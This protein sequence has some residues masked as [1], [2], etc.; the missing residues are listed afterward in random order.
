MGGLLELVG[1][2]REILLGGGVGVG[3]GAFTVPILLKN[4]P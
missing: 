1:G 3:L 4:T 2:L